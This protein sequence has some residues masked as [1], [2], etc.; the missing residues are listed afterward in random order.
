MATGRRLRSEGDRTSNRKQPL[1]RYRQPRVER[2]IGVEPVSEIILEVIVDSK[3]R[4]HRPLSR[5]AGVPGQTNA[6]LPEHSGVIF[7]ERRR[8]DSRVGL[9]DSVRII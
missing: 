6:R 2:R 9:D 5:A 8:I 3:A 7:K 1:A 4:A